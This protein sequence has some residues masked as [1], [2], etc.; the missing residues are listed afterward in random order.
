MFIKAFGGG[1]LDTSAYIVYDEV[2]GTGAIIDTPLGTA[3]HMLQFAREV[4]I[5]VA[6]IVNTH[7]HW[8]NIAE[9]VTLTEATGAQLCAHSW[10]SARLADPSLTSDEELARKVRP[11]R[12][13][14]Y[15]G[16]GELLQIGKTEL[17]VWHTPGHSPGS[18]CLVSHEGGAVFTGDTLQCLKVGRT[19]H[20]GGSKAHLTESLLRLATLPDS[21]RVYPAHGLPTTIRSER[22]L[23]E[24]ATGGE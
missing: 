2:G 3:R 1:P 8:D 11:S 13:D 5:K 6:Y 24:L 23:L 17:E 19:D 16:N 9:N 15:L 20:P 21:T 14:H 18:V 10:D 7:G 12:A 4:G 22:W